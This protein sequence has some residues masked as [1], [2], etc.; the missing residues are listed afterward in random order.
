[1]D[2]IVELN[3]LHSLM[4]KWPLL[5][6][7]ISVREAQEIEFDLILIDLTSVICRLS[8]IGCEDSNFYPSFV[9]VTTVVLLLVKLSV[10]HSLY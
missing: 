5:P 6:L 9:T 1:M 8:V 3:Y 4:Q 7:N 2:T 10:F